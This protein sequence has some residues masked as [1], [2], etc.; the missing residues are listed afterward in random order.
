MPAIAGASRMPYRKFLVFNAIGGGLWAV[1]VVVAAYLAGSAWRQVQSSLGHAGEIGA[2]AA[3]VAV[4]IVLIV[5]RL[6]RRRAV[7]R[8]APDEAEV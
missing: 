7:R 5:R 4:V 3:A 6:R 1:V 2:G 8:P